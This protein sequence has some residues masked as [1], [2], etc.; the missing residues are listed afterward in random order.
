MTNRGS[1]T[2]K[3]GD[4]IYLIETTR[5][6]DGHPPEVATKVFTSKAGF[7]AGVRAVK[8]DIKQADML[9]ASSHLGWTPWSVTYRTFQIEGPTWAEMQF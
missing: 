1:W 8:D 2:A 3:V 7:A 4:P 9:R 6:T 5:A